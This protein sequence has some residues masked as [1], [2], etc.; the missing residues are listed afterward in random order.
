MKLQNYKQLYTSLT[1]Q[2][3]LILAPLFL[4]SCYQINALA[5]STLSKDELSAQEAR[6]LLIWKASLDNSSQ[7]L[8]SSWTEGSSHCNGWYGIECNQAGNVVD[9][10]FTNSGLKGTL[11][12]LIFHSFLMYSASTFLR[13]RCMGESLPTLLLFPDLP[14]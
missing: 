13:T 12:I 3:M 2:A 6:A 11:I 9:M 8:L 7:I 4:L 14:T 5:S 1:F 10:N